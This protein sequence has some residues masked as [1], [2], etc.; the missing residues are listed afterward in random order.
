MLQAFVI[1][2]TFT[3]A[4][5]LVVGAVFFFIPPHMK[6][7]LLTSLLAACGLLAPL[8]LPLTAQG[9]TLT[10]TARS[11]A[12]NARAAALTTPVSVTFS[13][14]LNP[15]TTGNIKVFSQQYRGQRTA[16]VS[17]SGATATL[18]PTV[19]T[20]G[21]Q[22]AGFKPGETLF[23]TVPATVQSTG[24]AAAVRQ[25][26]QFTAAT[27]GT[28][29][30]N[31]LAPATN[32]NPTVGNGPYSV[33]VGDVD[34]DGDLDLLTAN[35]ISGTVSVRLNDGTGN[36]IGGSDP[37]VGANPGSV[38]VGDVDGDGDLDLLTAN[39]G[40][41]TV[42][43]RLNDGTGN[44]I[45]GSDPAVGANP[46]R[47]AVGD[48]DGDGDLDLL[49]AAG[50]NTVSVRL[51]DG[52]GNFTGGSDPTVGTDPTSVAVGDVDG[53]GDL[54]LLTANQGS[55]TVSVRLNDGTG[56]FTAPAT[57]PNPAVGTTP[58]SVA[59]G[60]VDGDG[61]LDLLA[62]NFDD[63]TVSVRL[64][65]GTGHFTA[66]A[67]NA[68]LAVGNGPI[69]VAVGD[70]DG[71]GD[72]D[73]L[74]AIQS[75]N[76][77]SVQ[78]NDGAGNFTAPAT[79][80][81]PTVGD[82]PS[83]VAVGDVDGDGDLDLLTANYYDNTAS[84]R[85]NGGTGLAIAS[86]T[87]TSG[88]T[89]T[90][91]SLTGTGLTGA[92]AITFSGTSGNV[93]TTGFSVA[94]STSITGVVVPSG[95]VTGTLT[96]TTPGG[97]SAASSQTF[98]VTVAPTISSAADNPVAR[99]GLV[100]LNGTGLAGA[101]G[102]TFARSGFSPITLTSF[103]S[104]TATALAFALPLAAP[105]TNGAYNVTVTN[106]NGTSAAFSLSLTD[107]VTWNGS[108]G[109][110]WATATNWSPPAVPNTYLNTTVVAAA[111]QPT[112]TGTQLVQNVTVQAG[113]SLTLAATT[114]PTTQLTLGTSAFNNGSL[115][116][117][118]GST[119]TQG[120][121]SELY[122]TQ[123]MTNNGATFVLDATSEIG[124]GG[125][126]H[127]LNG[128]AGVTFQTLTVG[129]Q[130]SYDYLSIEV[131]VQVRRKLGVY[132]N[133]TTALGAGGSLTLLSNA[134][135]T[136]LVENGT[137]STVTGTVTVQRY[138]D[139]TTNAGPGYRHY[140]AP[141]SNT[142]V[143]DLATTTGF[144]PTLTTS[145]N[146]SATPGTTTPFPTVFGYDQSRVSL[147]N[148]SAPF[149]RGFVVPAALT[150]PLAVG[151]GY[152]VNIA[153]DQLVDFVG[154]LTNGDQPPLVLS[155]VAGN[156]AAG[157]QLVG[158]PYPAP[159]NYALVEGVDRANLDAA[160]YVYGST[161]QYVGTYRS[162]VNGM[163]GNPVLPVAQGF[164]VRVSDS[165]TS[166]A[167][168]FRN[169]QRLTAPDATAFQRG[170]A[171][172]RPLV[173][174]ELRGSTG[175][176]ADALYAYA[177]TGAT[178]AFDSQFDAAKL[179]N[180]TGL[181]LSST[182]T[183]GEALSIDAR[184]AFT[185]ATVLPLAL[186]VPAAGTYSFTAVALN[187][188]P[189]ALDAFL[190]DAQTGQTVNLRLQPAYA[191]SVSPTQA[192]VLISGRFTLHFAARAA[193]ATAPA[194]SAAQVALYPNPAHDRFTVLVPTVAG[195]TQV[196]VTLLNVLGQV[197]R[198]QAAASGTAFAVETAGLATGVYTLRMQV[199][200][201]TLT[202]RVVLQ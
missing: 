192:A 85:L 11:P 124:F 160:I 188:I 134:T 121:G 57:N 154:T 16:S 108:A 90:T 70:V 115:V 107:N 98:T 166:G 6:N 130:G 25:V 30:G 133:S 194:L 114:A 12:R 88:P 92:T 177:E 123:N 34:G 54:D 51:N 43:V 44:F 182:A 50:S 3:A 14:N 97:T 31:F 58:K 94:S 139:P 119:L 55:N 197:M 84:V 122:I 91:I 53:D 109:T 180:T 83:S 148:S 7:S 47:V 132:N 191:F 178:P 143:A 65:D 137:G 103:S 38:A 187:N 46:Q 99:G 184:P 120:A 40:S 158:N 66:P 75:D 175:T 201:A 74:T 67:T 35:L 141:V 102:V 173:Q 36:F 86:F 81:N 127:V 37:A 32:A 33:A 27:G 82:T 61:D 80:P 17:T 20:T 73:L 128:T 89:G 29:R 96:V 1:I 49:A 183:S 78:L 161:S 95:A 171:D 157:W 198:T 2:A 118:T 21:S 45:G 185:A 140:S 19:P 181:N 126:S 138:I 77:V 170:A 60:D 189:A 101:T 52:T 125:P 111:A 22:V 106:A 76:T 105:N 142:T 10:V 159:L 153:G 42:S 193:L 200:T 48:V 163:G 110:A 176:L 151:K 59:V 168:T 79:N 9:Q 5:P 93:V 164:F 131:P 202:K 162:Y 167:L 135:G 116:L 172:A 146:A 24:G 71:D 100:T 62:A 147:A 169:S 152:A 196:H 69:S 156:S 136:A 190:S 144:T 186:G 112:V 8:A 117:A 68:N 149:D 26:Y 15:A 64:N 113:A 195:A 179:A 165:Q 72:L 28:G 129:E 104:N 199:G 145:Y 174:L 23:V 56:N 4:P 150:T 18:A 41:N 39:S 155:R 63:N 87:P 13:A